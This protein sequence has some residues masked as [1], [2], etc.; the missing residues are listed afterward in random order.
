MQ[1]LLF[2]FLVIGIAPVALADNQMSPRE[3]IYS[4]ASQGNVEKLKDLQKSGYSLDIPDSQ[5]QQAVCEAVAKK[6]KK[7][8]KTLQEAGANMKVYCPYKNP[9]ELVPMKYTFPFT[10]SIMAEDA[11]ALVNETI[12][13]KK[14]VLFRPYVSLKA[15]YSKMN[16]DTRISDTIGSYEGAKKDWNWGGSVAAGMKICA[17]RVELEYNQSATAKDTRHAT[18]GL[19]DTVRGNQSYRSYMLNGYFDIPTYT[20][21][22]PYIGAGIGMARVKNRLAFLNTDTITKQKSNNFAYQLMAGITYALNYHWTLDVGYRYVDNG[23]TSWDIAGGA[24]KVDFDSTE[25][26]ITAGVRYTF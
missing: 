1:K 21:F 24:A 4:Y 8:F 19:Y 9:N 26:Q 20:A 3:A 15:N 23:D 6:D 11:E 16:M 10:A 22:H 14:S 13:E 18:G 12:S 7:A 17:F 2:L 5:G 25:H